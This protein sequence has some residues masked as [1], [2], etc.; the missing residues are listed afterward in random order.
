MFLAN[1]AT[2]L[3]IFGYTDAAVNE[4]IHYITFLHM[5]RAGLRA[6][7]FYDPAAQKHL[8]A[9][10]QAR[11]GITLFMLKEGLVSLEEQREDGKL[12]QLYVKVD[13]ARVLSEGTAVMGRL[14]V[15]LQVPKSIADGDGARAFYEALTHPPPAWEGEIR[16]LVIAQRLP[17]RKFVQPNSVLEGEDVVLKEYPLTKEGLI[18]SCLER[19]I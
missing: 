13:R 4:D 16:D 1:H 12:V 11:M 8:Q 19:Q 18:Q 5:A 9:H 3:G 2:I 7:E 10:M 15:Q 14:L 17:R 6:L